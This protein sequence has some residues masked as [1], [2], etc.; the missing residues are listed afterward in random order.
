MEI[1]FL[2]GSHSPSFSKNSLILTMAFPL[3]EL[4]ETRL[5]LVRLQNYSPDLFFSLTG[6]S[7]KP[8]NY[9]ELRSSS[10]DEAG[11]FLTV[12]Y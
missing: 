5:F 6:L 9:S 2:V 3:K 12:F 1:P 10:P 7:Y 11:C 8:S 4:T